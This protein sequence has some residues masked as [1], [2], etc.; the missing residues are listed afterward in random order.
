MGQAIAAGASG[1]GEPYLLI[2][3]PGES[4]GSLAKAGNTFCL[5]GSINAAINAAIS[6]D[7]TDVPG[8]AEANDGFGTSVAGDATTSPSAPSAPAGSAVIRSSSVTTT[9]TAWW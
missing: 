5:R 8:T 6:Q 4:L 7:S 3:V 2:G 9:G 1:A